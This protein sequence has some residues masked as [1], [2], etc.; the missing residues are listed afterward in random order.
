MRFAFVTFIV[1]AFSMA[2]LMPVLAQDTSASAALGAAKADRA[3]ELQII[4]ENLKRGEAERLRIASEIAA[5]EKDRA[6]IESNLVAVSAR[7]REAE[8][9]IAA[10]RSR[11]EAA[12]AQEEA[13]SQSLASRR[14][15]IADVLGT[16]QRM[17]HRPPPAVLV[18]PG[19]IVSAVRASLQIGAVL[20]EMR[21]EAEQLAKDV[22]ALVASRD[23]QAREKA[24]LETERRAVTDDQQRLTLLVSARQNDVQSHQRR[25]EQ[26]EVK[27]EALAMQARSLKE[28]IGRLE[29]DDAAAREAEEASSQ[30]PPADVARPS[31][32]STTRLAP[33]VAFETLRSTLPLPAAGQILRR[34]GDVDGTGG[35]ERGVT[36]STPARAIVTAPADGTVAFSGP[37]RSYG[38]VLILNGGNGFHL[39]FIGMERANVRTGQFVLAGEPIGVMPRESRPLGVG[40]TTASV[41]QAI[42][43]DAGAPLLYIEMRKDGAPIDS[44]SWWAQTEKG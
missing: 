43:A 4:E 17:G 28:L 31:D 2:G 32:P 20:P 42:G 16:L 34:F 38:T 9:N 1:A 21:A 6:A 11:L 33:K 8:N 22:E 10:A 39:V 29:S 40:D 25:L 15:V 24:V 36:I 41:P 30:V 27:V 18:Q 35:S 19:D 5:I 23:V 3:K 37:F 12:L 7:V 14:D 13:L 26:E 44:R